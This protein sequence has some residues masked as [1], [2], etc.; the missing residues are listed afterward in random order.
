MMM[1]NE[2]LYDFIVRLDLIFLLL[3]VIGIS[4]YVIALTVLATGT[5]WPDLAASMIAAYRQSTAD[6]AIANITCRLLL[7]QI[8]HARNTKIPPYLLEILSSKT[9]PKY[10]FN[11]VQTVSL[12]LQYPD[13]YRKR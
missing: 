4:S 10:H 6:S 3:F 9:L 11:I 13:K 5:S 12:Y 1:C 7:F 8:Y 2:Y